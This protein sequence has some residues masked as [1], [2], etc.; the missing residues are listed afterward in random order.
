[1]VWWSG[2]GMCGVVCVVCVVWCGLVWCNVHAL[3]FCITHNLQIILIEVHQ[4]EVRSIDYSNPLSGACLFASAG[5]RLIHVFDANNNY[6]LV[7]T[8]EEH[9][10]AIS[11]ILFVY[12]LGNE[13]LRLL[14]CSADRALVFRQVLHQDERYE[15]V[16]TDQVC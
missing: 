12:N 4:S 3:H 1:M 13:M 16:I 11:C 2:C 8:L 9:L 10:A 14:S 6:S 7:H 5:D 15:F